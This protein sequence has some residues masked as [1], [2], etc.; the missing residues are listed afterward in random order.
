MLFFGFIMI[1]RYRRILNKYQ[2]AYGLSLFPINGLLFIAQSIFPQLQIEMFVLAVT[3]Y[4]A[5]ATIQRPELIVNSKTLA[6]TSIAFENDLKKALSLEVPFKIIFIKITN[7][8]NINMYVGNDKFNELLK[9]VTVFLHELSHKQ[10]LKAVPFYL[11]D[12]VYALPTEDQ[13][14][15]SI[16]KILDA[17]E[18]YFSQVFILDGV[19]INLETRI[20]VVCSPEDVS[21]FE[22]FIYL[23]KTYYKILEPTG[24]PQWLRDYI[25]DRNFIIRN[26]I[27]KIIERA[28]NEERFEVYFQPIYSVKEKK[29]SSAEALVRLNDPEFGPIPP[30][31]FISYAEKTNK[32]HVIGDFVLKK[33]CQFIGSKEGQSLN[34]DYIEVNMS[35]VQCFE[36]DLITKIRDLLEKYNLEPSQLRLE[37]T[38][39][40]A[41]FNPMIVEKNIRDLNNIGIKFSL[42]DYGTGFSNIKKVISLPFDIVKLNKA[43]IDEIENP[44]TESLVQDTIH[45]LKALGKQI[46]IEG[47]ESKERAQIFIELKNDD[48]EACDYLQGF[49]FSKPLPQAEFVKFIKK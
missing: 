5:F 18:R 45:M 19:K 31:L 1:L 33:V 10:K 42:D 32:I 21:N 22:Y 29:F 37:I 3:C 48:V 14:D 23:S 26:N 28:I 24:K 47:I 46:L 20:C 41:S 12:Y 13:S 39:N 27:Q 30:G 16:D 4:L 15:S 17:L 9:K 8:R 6:Q 7:H 11:N 35:V 34:L 49:F 2:V 38:E 36:T 44:N 40:A 25:S 43:F